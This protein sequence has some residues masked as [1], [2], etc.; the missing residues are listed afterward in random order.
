MYIFP[1]KLLI[2]CCIFGDGKWNVAMDCTWPE[3][4]S[5]SLQIPGITGVFTAA[6]VGVVFCLNVHLCLMGFSDIWT[7][8]RTR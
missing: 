5:I 6:A 1:V 3:Q 2:I 4:K 8:V 7:Q